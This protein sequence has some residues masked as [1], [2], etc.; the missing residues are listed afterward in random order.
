VLNS[1]WTEDAIEVNSMHPHHSD[2]SFRQLH[3]YALL[4]SARTSLPERSDRMGWLPS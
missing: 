2:A 4:A 3:H 1:A